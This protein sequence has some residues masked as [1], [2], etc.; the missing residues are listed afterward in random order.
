MV[1]WEFYNRLDLVCLP[2]L[3]PTGWVILGKSMTFRT[4][5]FSLVNGTPSAI[6]YGVIRDEP[7]I[8]RTPRCSANM[9]AILVGH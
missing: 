2:A 5:G 3:P 1:E 8:C 4:L 9:V 7:H 6:R